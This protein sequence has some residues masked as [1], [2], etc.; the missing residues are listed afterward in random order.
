MD[1]ASR[2][3]RADARRLGQGKPRSQIR[4]PE[5]LRRAAVA[6]ARRR[7]AQ[8]GSRRHLARDIGVSE[9]TLTKWL[10]PTPRPGLRPVALTIPSQ[11]APHVGAQPVLI[12][13]TGVRVEGLDRDALIVVLRAL[14]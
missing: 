11:P 14:A 5:A 12:T 2:R 6:L 4:Y 7:Q 1:E 8:G 9:P 3:L 13:P 10:R